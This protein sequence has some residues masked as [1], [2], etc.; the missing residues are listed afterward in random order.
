MNWLLF[1]LLSF[2]P[3]LLGPVSGLNPN[4]IVSVRSGQRPRFTT[5]QRKSL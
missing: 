5:P 2:R 4:P 3:E 1:L